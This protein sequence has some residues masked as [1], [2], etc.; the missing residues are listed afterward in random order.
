MKDALLSEWEDRPGGAS[1]SKEHSICGAVRALSQRM[2][3]TVCCSWLAGIT[4]LMLALW[5]QVR[6]LQ[7][8]MQPDPR[9]AVQSYIP[10]MFV[11]IRFSTVLKANTRIP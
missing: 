11:R 5:M 6:A 7:E 8:H 9:T 3:T 4:M 10:G 1:S 2:V